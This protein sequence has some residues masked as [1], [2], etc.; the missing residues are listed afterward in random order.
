ML[1]RE[2]KEMLDNNPQILEEEV[3][4]ESH[5]N[6]YKVVMVLDDQG[7]ISLGLKKVKW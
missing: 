3:L 7:S 5:K 2:I 4:A 1:W 6:L